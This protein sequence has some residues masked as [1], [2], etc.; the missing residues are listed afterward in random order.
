MKRKQVAPILKK[1]KVGE[2]EEYPYRQKDSVE[3]TIARIQAATK[4]SKRPKKFSY[5]SLENTIQVTRTF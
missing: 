3:T 5:K 2:K 4:D 1:M